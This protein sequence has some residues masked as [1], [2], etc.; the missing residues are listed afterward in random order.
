MWAP[1]VIQMGRVVDYKSFEAFCAC[2][3]DNE[4][5]YEDRRLR[6]VSE[7][8][9]TFEYWAKHTRLPRINGQQVN[10][11]PEDT[12]HSPYLTMKHGENKAI[13]SY[14][15]FEDVVLNFDG[16]SSPKMPM[17]PE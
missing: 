14:R 6:Y 16:S 17:L 10:L 15:G 5:Q 2:V 8:N 13:I 11:N 7:E 1:I 12:Y 9:E 4:F 3:K